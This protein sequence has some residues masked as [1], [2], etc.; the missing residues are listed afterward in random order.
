MLSKSSGIYNFLFSF[1]FPLLVKKAR[2]EYTIATISALNTKF[3]SV[4]LTEWE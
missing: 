2:R 4:S 1:K 3:I